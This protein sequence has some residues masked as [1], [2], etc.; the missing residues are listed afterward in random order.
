VG[1]VVSTPVVRLLRRWRD[2]LFGQWREGPEAPRR[3]SDIVEAY[4]SLYPRAT[5]AQWAAFAAG[6]GDECYRAGWL[7]G[8]EHSERDPR[9]RSPTPEQVA[10]ALTPGWR[11]S[12]PVR[13]DAPDEVV[14]EEVDQAAVLQEQLRR[15]GSR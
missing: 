5:R 10:D 11:D 6:H 12:D 7:R 14:P 15:L 4:A 13:I 9:P 2:R 1:D 3:L 8:Y